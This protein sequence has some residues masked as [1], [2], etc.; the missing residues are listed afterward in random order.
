MLHSENFKETTITI[1]GEKCR[2]EYDVAP[3]IENSFRG[4]GNIYMAG[5]NEPL[6][7]TFFTLNDQISGYTP[8][9]IKKEIMADIVDATTG[10][11]LPFENL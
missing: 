2:M 7:F 9:N 6:E 4:F 1:N 11:R 5:K 3:A 8:M 10:Q